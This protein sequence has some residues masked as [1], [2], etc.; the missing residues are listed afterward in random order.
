MKKNLLQ[1]LT[2]YE[3]ENDIIITTFWGENIYDISSKWMS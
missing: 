2:Y 1:V 3:I